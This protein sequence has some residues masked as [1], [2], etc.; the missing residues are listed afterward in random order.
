MRLQRHFLYASTIALLTA[1]CPGDDSGTNDSTTGSTGAAT[2]GGPNTT[3]GDPDPTTGDPD[4]TTG[5]PDPTTGMADSSSGG[6][7]DSSSGGGMGVNF[8][9]NL[10]GYPHDGQDVALVVIDADSGTEVL[11]FSETFAGME[12]TLADTN[13]VLTDGGTYDVF[14][15]VD[16]NGSG[17]CDAPP[18]DHS[19][20]MLGV[21]AG[22]M[23]ISADHTHDA[24]WVDVCG[25]F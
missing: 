2:T 22:P 7:A 1:G 13:G 14:W 9:W 12:I 21:A 24:N 8:E 25:N 18:D 10:M 5:D 4:P 17:S 19:W 23:G 3:T 6:M 11:S 20:E 15:Y 16:V